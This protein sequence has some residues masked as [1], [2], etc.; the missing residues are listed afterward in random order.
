MSSGTPKSNPFLLLFQDPNLA[1]RQFAKEIDSKFITIEAIIGGGE[2]GDVCRGRLSVPG[3]CDFTYFLT[4]GFPIAV[5]SIHFCV[6]MI[7]KVYVL[8]GPNVNYGHI[9]NPNLVLE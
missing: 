7:N 3:N 2:F 5:I 6:P 9:R 1:V 8:S 4:A